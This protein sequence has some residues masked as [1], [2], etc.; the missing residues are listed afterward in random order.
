MHPA[1]VRQRHW[2]RLVPMV[3]FALVIA[4]VAVVQLSAH[5]ADTLLSQGKPATASSQEGADV[6]AANAVD[7]NAGTR[8]SSV[9]SDPQWLRVD[10]GQTATISQ[11]VLQWEG[12]YG[13][14]Y[15]IQTSAD[16]TTW[17]SIYTT[18]D[19][20]GRHRDPQRHRQRPLRPDERHRTGQRLR[21][22]AVRV[23]GLRLATAA[24][25]P[26]AA[27]TNAAQGK[28]A[29][30]S[31]SEG[32]DVGPANA[33]D[34][35]AGTRWSSRSAT[36]SGSRSTSAPPQT[37]CQVV[38]QWE[39]AY[40]KAY[41]IQT[42]ADGTTWTDDLHHHHRRRRHRD[43]RP[44]PAP[45]ATCGCTAPPAAAATATRCGSS[46]SSPAAPAPAEQPAAERPGPVRPARQLDQG[47]ERRLRRRRP[48]PRPA[49]PTGCCAPAPSTPAAPPTG[50]PA[51]SRRPA[52][53]PPTSPSTAPA[54]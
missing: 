9:F 21:L 34:G 1:S 43:P 48:T 29:T 24:P 8:W 7:G 18:D 53:P 46:R 37:I 15:Q 30:A 14:S 26:R 19:R 54:S 5:A 23:Q 32:A 10:L 2:R 52:T 42:S 31:S 27:P 36:R 17:T 41:Q 20:R 3:V 12:A 45:A 44:S 38:L 13:K 11:V 28:P 40:G 47:L 49:A 6:A 4:Y 51:R 16:G 22:L 33:V 25:R 35:N 39:G 50:A